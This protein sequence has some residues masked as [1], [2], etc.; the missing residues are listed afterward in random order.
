M[1]QARNTFH[2][3]EHYKTFHGFEESDPRELL[4]H[5]PNQLKTEIITCGGLSP[6][7]NNIIKGL[8]KTL[9]GDYGVTNMV[10]GHWNNFFTHIPI[11][12]A[13]QERRMV[14]LDESLWRESSAP[15]NRRN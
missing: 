12:L 8:V 13:T 3:I 10:V 1:S 2:Q 4:F 9:E 14:D 15:H 11:N 5:D 7:L 6:R